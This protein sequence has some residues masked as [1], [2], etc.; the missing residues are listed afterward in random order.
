[1]DGSPVK[2]FKEVVEHAWPRQIQFGPDALEPVRFH[3][4]VG[5]TLVRGFIRRIRKYV[6]EAVV[7]EPSRCLLHWSV[8][9]AQLKY[10]KPPELWDG[11]RLT[12]FWQE[13]FDK[14]L[15]K[16]IADW[17][18]LQKNKD[19]L[20]GVCKEIFECYTIDKRHHDKQ[21][22][23]YR[24]IEKQLQEKRSKHLISRD[25]YR[26]QIDLAKSYPALR[27]PIKSFVE[28]IELSVRKYADREVFYE[29]LVAFLSDLPF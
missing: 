16:L 24:S 15:E 5:G 2:S 13:R 19:I 17:E 7:V 8:G 25:D 22:E 1:M 14:K 18:N 3:Q 26:K 12:P 20:T 6:A 23:L 28:E 4:E 10:A 27:D 21:V 11:D 9:L 29:A